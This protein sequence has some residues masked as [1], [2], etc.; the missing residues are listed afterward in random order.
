MPEHS[1]NSRIAKC[2][3]FIVASVAGQPDSEARFSSSTSRPRPSTRPAGRAAT[4]SP[5]RPAGSSVAG[6]RADERRQ[7]SKISTGSDGVLAGSQRTS[8]TAS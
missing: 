5:R 7:S 6:R 2:R 3:K 1:T 4:T 8:V